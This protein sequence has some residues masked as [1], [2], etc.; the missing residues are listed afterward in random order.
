MKVKYF[1]TSSN[2]NV[3]TD[4][5]AECSKNINEDFVD[6]VSLLEDGRNIGMP[7]SRPLFNIFIGLHELRLK[8]S[9]GIFRFFYYIKKKDGIYFIHAIKKKKEELLP[10]EKNLVLKRIKEI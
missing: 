1:H 3:I 4:F 6:A 2:R 10:K 9:S 8:D 5:L 7:L